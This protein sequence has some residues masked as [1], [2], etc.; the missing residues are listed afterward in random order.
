MATRVVAPIIVRDLFEWTGAV[1]CGTKPRCGAERRSI[2]TICHEGAAGER[3]DGDIDE[4]EFSH[5]VLSWC[6]PQGQRL[7]AQ[8]KPRLTASPDANA[9]HEQTFREHLKLEK[10]FRVV[11]PV[12]CCAITYTEWMFIT[13]AEWVLITCAQSVFRPANGVPVFASADC[14]KFVGEMGNQAVVGAV[15]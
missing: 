7:Q 3:S 6:R 9:R 10:S 13:Y 2:S 5:R 14:G 15:K 8:R 4:K 12:E 11:V 1:D